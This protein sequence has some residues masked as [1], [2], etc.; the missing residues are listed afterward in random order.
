MD[1]RAG[2]HL[3]G[4]VPVLA[5][6]ALVMTAACAGLFPPPRNRPRSLWPVAAGV[7]GVAATAV[8]SAGHL[9]RG[10]LA[11]VDWAALA[12]IAVLLVM[13][14]L[15]RRGWGDRGAGALAVATVVLA[16]W[17]GGGMSR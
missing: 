13:A 8:L 7:A 14:W 6:L 1:H 11:R 5:E 15:R 9:L 4:T 3:A 10:G 16:I 12:P 2:L 17:V